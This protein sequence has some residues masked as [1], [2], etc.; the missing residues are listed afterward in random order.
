MKAYQ[1]ADPA[2]GLELKD[3]PV[4]ELGLEKVLIAV[5][6]AGLCHADLYI[7]K[8][9]GDTWIKEEPMTLGYEV[10]GVVAKP[11]AGVSSIRVG[12]KR[13][14]HRL[15]SRLGRRIGSRA[16]GMRHGGGYAE[17]ALACLECVVPIPD[18]V[19]FAQAACGYGS[20]RDG[21]SRCSGWGM[22][23]CFYGHC[24]C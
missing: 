20:D 7:I 17:Y 8:G 3:L 15:C 6:A 5:E 18:G 14:S 1:F 12:T 9:H 13:S 24:C 16:I 11:G 4:P 21:L 19:S 23:N 2:K 22:C 10:A